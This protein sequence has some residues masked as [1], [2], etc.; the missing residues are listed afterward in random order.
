MLP[1]FLGSC[2]LMLIIPLIALYRNR[3]IYGSPPNWL[4]APITGLCVLCIIVPF[5]YCILTQ[6]ID[7][8]RAEELLQCYDLLRHVPAKLATVCFKCLYVFAGLAVGTYA[9]GCL[10]ALAAFIC[11]I[12]SYYTPTM[13]IRTSITAAVIAPLSFGLYYAVQSIPI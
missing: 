12:A 11:T 5:C 2:V 7:V 10:S 1:Y 3:T 13:W 4:Y 8:L 6:Y 9:A